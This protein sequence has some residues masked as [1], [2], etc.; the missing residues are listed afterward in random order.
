[1]TTIKEFAI[2][3]PIATTTAEQE[4]LVVPQITAAPYD[5]TKGKAGTGAA[6]TWD[7]LTD[8]QEYRVITRKKV[9]TTQGN[10][11]FASGPAMAAAGTLAKK[12]V[13]GEG[14]SIDYYAE[15]LT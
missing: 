10:E 8:N 1:M 15:K 11:A 4:Y 14:Y 6:L 12:P 5:W 7:G 13:A 3:Y 9:V 2:I